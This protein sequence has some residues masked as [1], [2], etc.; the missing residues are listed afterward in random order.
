MID[1]FAMLLDWYFLHYVTKVIN[2]E[3]LCF[4]SNVLSVISFT[5]LFFIQLR[6]KVID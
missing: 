6:V 2:R 3:V 1:F 5:W 4:H